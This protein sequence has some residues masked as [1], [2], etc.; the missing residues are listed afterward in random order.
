MVNLVIE[1]SKNRFDTDKVTNE[2]INRN[3]KVR[4]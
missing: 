1:L 3:F 4:V 2:E